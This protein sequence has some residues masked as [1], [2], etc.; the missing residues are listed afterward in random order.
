V[1]ARPATVV[2]EEF[3]QGKEELGCAPRLRAALVGVTMVM[4]IHP[5]QA[6]RRCAQG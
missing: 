4:Q 5:K 1:E 6:D 2:I 3:S